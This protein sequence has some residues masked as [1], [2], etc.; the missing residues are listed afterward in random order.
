[1]IV[2]VFHGITWNECDKVEELYAHGWP[3]GVDPV[4]KQEVEGVT[5]WH[6]QEV[7]QRWA[8]LIKQIIKMTG[9]TMDQVNGREARCSAD[10][11]CVNQHCTA[12]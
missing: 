10:V 1:M 8:K 9:L 11:S 6:R 3:E 2:P 4:E 12:V 5:G 7:L